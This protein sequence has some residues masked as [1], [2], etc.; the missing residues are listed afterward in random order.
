MNSRVWP[1]LASRTTRTRSRSPGR[2]RSCP[3]RSRGPL[4]TSLIPVA[5]T[6]IA[7]GRPRAKHWYH[8]NPSGVTNPSSLARQGTIAGTQVRWAN[9][10]GPTCTGENSRAAAASAALGQTPPLALCL[11]RSGGRHIVSVG[12][13]HSRRFNFDFRLRFHERYHLHHTH[14]REILGHD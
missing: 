14:D 13:Y 4:G 6:T 10:T 2:N 3:A 11:I 9:V 1:S 7:P 8:S 5:S 12:W